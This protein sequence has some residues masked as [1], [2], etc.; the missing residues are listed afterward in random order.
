MYIYTYTNTYM[1][2]SLRV[3]VD[4]VVYTE[5]FL[6]C[7][8]LVCKN[9]IKS[10]P[11]EENGGRRLLVEAE[12]EYVYIRICIHVCKYTCMRCIHTYRYAC[13]D[14]CMDICKYICIY[15]VCTEGMSTS[16]H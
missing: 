15:S 12:E 5:V 4:R 16:F 2:I 3:C 14:V 7:T 10:K 11:K 6:L 9:T 13:M 8:N 1:Y